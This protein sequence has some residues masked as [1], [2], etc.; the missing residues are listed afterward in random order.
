MWN[1][2]LPDS[3]KQRV[4]GGCRGGTGLGDITGQ[5]TRSFSY[6]GGRRNG[7]ADL[8]GGT[9]IIASHTVRNTLN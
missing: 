5:G 2:K 3:Q 9:V 6:A 1:L 7:S 4:D 8:T